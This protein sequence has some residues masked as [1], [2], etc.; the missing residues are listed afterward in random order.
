MRTVEDFDARALGGL[1]ERIRNGPQ[2]LEC[3]LR[4]GPRTVRVVVANNRRAL[5]RN[6]APVY[7]RTVSD[8]PGA[9]CT[10]W[11]ATSR[12]EAALLSGEAVTV[13]GTAKGDTITVASVK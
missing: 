2:A 8:V 12:R 7:Q 3:E 1:L 6:V 11:P 9:I 13:T 5:G 4:T 10:G